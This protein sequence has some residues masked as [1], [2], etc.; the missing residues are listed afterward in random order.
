MERKT[1]SQSAKDFV[2]E[3]ALLTSSFSREGSEVD[4]TNVVTDID[5]YEHLDKP[6][7]TGTV[8]FVDVDRI[9]EKI[10]FYG[11][12]KFSMTVKLPE[13][14]AAAI[15]KNFYIDKIVKN[16]RTND[17][18]SVIAMHILED[19]GYLSEMINVNKPY[20]G[21]GYEIISKIVQ[22]FLGKEL[23]K[24]S[25]AGPEYET[26]QDAQSEFG[27][28]IPDMRPLR[29]ADWIK[30][31]I[32][33]SDASPFYFF[34]TLANDKL[35]LMP[36]S[37]M[38]ENNPVNSGV[39]PYR[40]SQAFTNTEN[41][42]I[43]DQAY[44]IEG[45]DNPLNEELL[46]INHN[47]FLNTVYA[48]HDVTRNKPIYPGHRADGN[49]VDKNRWTAYDMF[50]QRAN[51]GRALGRPVKIEEVYPSDAML[52]EKGGDAQAELI[53][54]RSASKLVSNIYS[55]D[56]YENNVYSLGESRTQGEF[57]ERLD[58][59]GLRNW[60][61]NTSMNFVVPGRNFLIGA[62]HTTIGNKYNLV[63]LAPPADG[64]NAANN[65]DS[66]KSGE[67]L[68]YAARH[69]F[70]REGYTVHLTGVKIVDKTEVSNNY[71][72]PDINIAE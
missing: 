23:S 31:R 52:E 30:D 27:V 71:V 47:G 19:I 68:I 5:I 29:A 17:S 15:Q 13:A 64:T 39:Q 43:D 66:S 57:L 1:Q 18:Q 55:T 53:H 40:Y 14:G 26:S 22:E 67:Y 33:T 58:A 28:V 51:I 38:L 46:K 48:F 32:T 34:S 63:F 60:L 20:F 8:T 41:M 2:L 10:N 42:S 11:I 36:L 49:T 6:Y 54:L 35:H 59:K 3:E 62:A 69:V 4:I 61:V 9:T 70:T 50:Q 44:I 37:A 45:Y 25:S 7:I 72:V 21:K 24:P 16:V 56:L 12:E 65:R